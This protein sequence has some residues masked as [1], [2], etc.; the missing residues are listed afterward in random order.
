[1]F[2]YSLFLLKNVYGGYRISFALVLQL[3][4][5]ARLLSD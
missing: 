5:R 3:R 2:L 1:M 4:I